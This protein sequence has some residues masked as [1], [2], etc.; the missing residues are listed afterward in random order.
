MAQHNANA[1]CM[2]DI[3]SHSIGSGFLISKV[4]EDGSA[5]VITNEHVM[6][7]AKK[8]NEFKFFFKI[9]DRKIEGVLD[10]VV[11]WDKKEDVALVLLRFPK[12]D[13]GARKLSPVVLSGDML[14][15]GAAVY[16]VN[17]QY[18]RPSMLKFNV[19]KFE[20]SSLAH[21]FLNWSTK[22]G[23]LGVLKT[24]KQKVAHLIKRTI[25]TPSIQV[26]LEN[27]GRFDNL[28]SPDELA[29]LIPVPSTYAEGKEGYK[30]NLPLL[31]GGS[32]GPVFNQFHKVIAINSE[33]D[34][35]KRPGYWSSY[36]TE[37]NKG[38]EALKQN[39]L[40]PELRERALEALRV[41]YN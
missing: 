5:F 26:G 12:N 39:I 21:K 13:A 18:L 35:A 16:S 22:F 8:K 24:K 40:I 14:E 4:A 1:V 32:G 10:T 11:S 25:T 31:G 9:G 28:S 34:D 27:T 38:V 3:G 15:R 20:R 30:L 23:L 33:S 41:A 37:I 36:P 29:P 2:I 7:S 6:S 17:F 19:K